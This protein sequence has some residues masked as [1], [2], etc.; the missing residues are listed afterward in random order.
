MLVEEPEFRSQKLE[1]ETGNQK[2]SMI[3]VLKQWIGDA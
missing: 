3:S 2:T 1:E